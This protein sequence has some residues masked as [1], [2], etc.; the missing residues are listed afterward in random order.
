MAETEAR[1]TK[2]SGLRDWFGRGSGSG[3]GSAI[4]GGES[5]KREVHTETVGRGSELVTR[6]TVIETRTTSDGRTETTRTVQESRGN[7]SGDTA[8]EVRCADKNIMYICTAR[9][10]TSEVVM[11]TD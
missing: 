7:T 3:G 9:C 6:T 11:A 10:R 1:N 5:V 4:S 8:H 2:S